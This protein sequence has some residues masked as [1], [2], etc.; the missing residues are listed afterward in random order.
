[1]LPELTPEEFSAALDSVAGEVVA[2][3][4]DATPPIDAV[5]LARSLGLAVAWDDRQQGRGRIVRLR[6][7][8]GTLAHGSILLRPDPRQERL[9]WAVAHEIG[10][11]CAC[12]VFQQLRVD[13]REAPAGARELV[14]NQL[15]GRLLLP[16]PWF[17]AHGRD[18]GWD[19]F[20]L[21]T[22]YQTASHELIARRML[23]FAPPVAITIFDHARRAFRRGNMPGRLPPPLPLELSAWQEAHQNGRPATASN[24][25]YSVR[26]WP[27]HEPEW[28]R[29]I[30]RTAWHAEDLGDIG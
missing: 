25:L 22:R 8:A 1:M 27:V 16:Q 15:A 11:S 28:K 20:E 24:H 14:A 9:Q 17:G 29:E 26:A 7:F 5:E 19:L 6:G 4:P 23:D 12:Q 10:E 2:T 13:P 3:L 18:C 30:V 21:K